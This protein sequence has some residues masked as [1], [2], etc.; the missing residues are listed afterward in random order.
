[1]GCRLLSLLGLPILFGAHFSG[2]LVALSNCRAESRLLEESSEPLAESLG[3][4]LSPHTHAHTH[5]HTQTHYRNLILFRTLFNFVRCRL[6]ENE[7]YEYFSATFSHVFRIR[8]GERTKLKLYE[9]IT[10]EIF[11]T[12]NITKFR[13]LTIGYMQLSKYHIISHSTQHIFL[14]V[15]HNPASGNLRTLVKLCLEQAATLRDES[16]CES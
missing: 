12:R 2:L 11:S 10:Y 6:Y 9:L 14:A 15:Q 4:T 5:T 3:L 8:Y 1:M 16:K 13:Y 7:M